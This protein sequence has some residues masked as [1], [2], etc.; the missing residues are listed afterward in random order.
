M[1]VAG[2]SASKGGM[3][4]DIQDGFPFFPLSHMRW[5][6]VTAGIA[7]AGSPQSFS[8]GLPGLFHCRMV[9]AQLTFLT[10]SWLLLDSRV[11]KLLIL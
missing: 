11:L 4:V 7:W 1:W 2:A 5:L 8:A 3:G 6:V 10:G 9:L